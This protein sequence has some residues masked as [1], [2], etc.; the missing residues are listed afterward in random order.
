MAPPITVKPLRAEQWRELR[1]IRLRAL[2]DSP[3]AFLTTVAQ[4]EKEP[5]EF[6]SSRAALA[7]HGERW[8]ICLAYTDQGEAIGMAS[9]VEDPEIPGVVELVQMWV[10]PTWRHQSVGAQLVAAI[11]A[12]SAPRADRIRLGVAEDNHAAI[13]L[14][15]RCGFMPTG[16]EQPFEGRPGIATQYYERRWR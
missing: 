9:G 7:A 6:W 12:W 15:T 3:E 5:D 2:R 10:D 4:A 16:E 1:D 13:D 14:Y 11:I 8:G